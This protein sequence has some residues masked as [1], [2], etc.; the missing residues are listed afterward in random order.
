MGRTLQ[1]CGFHEDAVKCIG[2]E[3]ILAADYEVNLP[4]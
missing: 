1:L 2:L 4:Q 3:Q